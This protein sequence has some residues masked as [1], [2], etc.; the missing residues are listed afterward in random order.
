MWGLLICRGLGVRGRS[1]GF[2][3]LRLVLEGSTIK[4]L[5]IWKRS[6]RRRES[7]GVV[8]NRISDG[9]TMFPAQRLP[10]IQETTYRIN[11][12]VLGE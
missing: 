4:N 7:N 6:G 5:I 12:S 8:F 2:W 9:A 1:G 10:N 11:N 3:N